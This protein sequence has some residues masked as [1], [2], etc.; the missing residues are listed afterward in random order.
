MFAR[1]HSNPNVQVSS[2][3]VDR[4]S[5]GALV[6][7]LACT[8][9]FVNQYASAHILD[10]CASKIDFPRQQIN[11]CEGYF[12]PSADDHKSNL[13][14]PKAQEEPFCGQ[15]EWVL[16]AQAIQEYADKI[17]AGG[18]GSISASL[19][20]HSFRGLSHSRLDAT[21][22]GNKEYVDTSMCS[23]QAPNEETGD[24]VYVC[25]TGDFI[26]HYVGDHNV[27]PSR[28]F[29]NYIRKRYSELQAAGEI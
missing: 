5:C 8:L 24:C 3:K 22:L 9:F 25:W 26:G 29:Y 4:R 15:H 28:E 16:R 17:A 11:Q 12:R 10:I 21:I 19:Q 1:R 27:V 23:T 18:L 14:F 6:A 20:V 13:P 2:L 7:V